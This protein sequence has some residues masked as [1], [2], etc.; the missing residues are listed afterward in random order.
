M[1]E[2]EPTDLGALLRVTAGDPTP[3]ELAAIVAVVTEAYERENAQA[4][5]ES[6]PRRSAWQVSARGLRTPLQRE[7]GWGSR[8]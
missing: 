7:L 5:A 6:S 1:S 8:G 3:E 4:V 2:A